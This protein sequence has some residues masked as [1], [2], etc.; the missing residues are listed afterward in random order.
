MRLSRLANESDFALMGPGFTGTGWTLVRDLV[1]GSGKPCVWFASYETP[2]ARATRLVGTV[3]Q[4]DIEWDVTATQPAAELREAGF[5]DGV[6]RVRE[7][8]AAGDVYQVNLTLRATLTGAGGAELLTLLCRRETPRFAAWI[9]SRHI[10]EIVSA[11]PE[12]LFE[13]RGRILR[14]E[15]MKGTAAPGEAGRLRRSAKDR[16]ELAMITDLLRDDLH[17]LCEPRTVVVPRP[18]RLVEL[19]YVVQ[20]VAEVE[21]T[22]RPELELRDV[23][24]QLHPGGS[25]TGAP[26]PAACAMIRQLEETPRGA[27]CGVLAWEEA[28]TAR[29]ALLI[30]TA[31]RLDADRWE[32]GVGSGITWDSVPEAELEEVRLKLGAWTG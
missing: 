15:P 29:A 3:E 10:G 21:G 17:R 16:A 30:R 8:I 23:I 4:V 20:A 7:A 31:S 6:R 28:E 18:R 13:K 25:V 19:P 14:A 2:G 32:C 9:R 26:R 22:L 1:P 24:A 5:L 11:S 27:Y 12:M